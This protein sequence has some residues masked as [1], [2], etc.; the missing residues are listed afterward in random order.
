MAARQETTDCHI[1]F[2][3]VASYS[4]MSGCLKKIKYLCENET[5]KVT[6]G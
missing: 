1:L 4:R 3:S 6:E 5:L 2:P